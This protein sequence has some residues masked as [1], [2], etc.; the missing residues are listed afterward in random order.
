MFIF[1]VDRYHNKT[2]V[3]NF[4]KEYIENIFGTCAP[5]N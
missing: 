5:H 4:I 3:R 2:K 1:L